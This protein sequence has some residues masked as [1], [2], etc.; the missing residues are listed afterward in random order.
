MLV[1]Q[2]CFSSNLKLKSVSNQNTFCLWT[3]SCAEIWIKL[4]F[5]RN[6]HLLERKVPNNIPIKSRCDIYCAEK[7]TPKQVDKFWENFVT[8]WCK[9]SISTGNMLKAVR[10]C[11]FNFLDTNVCGQIFAIFWIQMFVDKF[12]QNLKVKLK[13]QPKIDF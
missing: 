4:L 3:F 8:N 1:F 11:R 13:H 7:E 6:W 10:N 12:L 2:G 9:V 5:S